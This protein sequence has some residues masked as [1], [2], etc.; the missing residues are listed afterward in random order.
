MSGDSTLYIVLLA[1][2]GFIIVLIY[3]LIIIA[4]VSINLSRKRI[5]A[6][7]TY[8]L[9]L[10]SVLFMLLLTI[11]ELPLLHIFVT[12]ILCSE[13][14][15]YM[16]GRTCFGPLHSAF[17]A[18]AIVIFL[19]YILVYMV[20]MTL[21]NEVDPCSLICFS[22]PQ[23]KVPL[24]RWIYKLI[25]V[26][27]YNADT[28]GKFIPYFLG[29]CLLVKLLI[30]SFRYRRIVF[31]N[32][33]LNSFTGLCDATIAWVY[34]CVLIQIVPILVN[35]DLRR[36]AVLHWHRLFVHNDPVHVRG[37]LLLGGKEEVRL[38]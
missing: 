16:G 15:P 22:G 17:F 3:I 21:Y 32:S 12:P 35:V 1:F 5:S 38:A 4:M 29:F 20:V 9:K 30:L 11:F 6:L 7:T 33:A 28:T 36:P 23:N 31:Y 37:L 2:A 8:T 25:I 10:L 18:V 26:L 24:F 19:M 13:S 27:F 34:L 14:S